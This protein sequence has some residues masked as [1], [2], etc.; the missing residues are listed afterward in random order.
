VLAQR[1]EIAFV[2]LVCF[3]CQTQTL[4]LI[5]GAPAAEEDDGLG[6]GILGDLLAADRP[7]EPADERAEADDPSR[8]GAPVSDADVERMRAYLADYEGDLIGLFERPGDGDAE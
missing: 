8:F 2:Q 1:E 6:Q 3:A 5:T 4:A 7:D